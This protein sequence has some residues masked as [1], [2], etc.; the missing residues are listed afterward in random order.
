MALDNVLEAIDRDLEKSLE[1]LYA[2][3]R[4]PSVST[5]PAYRGDCR[6]AAD[7]L[8]QEL[9]ALH[10]KAD[11]RETKGLPMVVGHS[12]QGRQSKKPHILFYGHYDVQPPDPLDQW[13][14]PPFEPWMASTNGAKRIVARGSA[15]DKGQLMTFL[16]ACR[17][18]IAVEGD[19]PLLVTVLFEGEEETG[20]P[21]LKPFLDANKKELSADLA[22]VCDTDMWD[23]RTPA[24]TTMLRGLVME[25]LTIIGSNRDLHSGLFG[26]AAIN[27]IR[28]LAHIL[29][30]LHDD[31]GRITIPGF[32]DGAEDLPA[33]VRAQWKNL[34]F[35]EQKFLGEFGLKRPAGEEGRSVLEQI[36]ARP[37]CDVNGI[38]SGYTGVGAKTVIPSK[39]SAKVSFRIVGEQDPLKVQGAFRDFVKKR[40]PSDCTAEFQSHGASPALQLP[41]SSPYLTKA[42][43]ALEEEWGT[44]AVLKGCGASIPIVGSFKRDLNMDSLLIGYGL[45]DDRVHSPNEKYN[46]SS[47]HK[48]TR[49][50]A[51]ILAGLAA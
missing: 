7:W 2:L 48:G 46:L 30:D 36:W 17:A 23:V 40:L 49:S 20:S 13:E 28:V 4:I 18:I 3:L 35:D 27:P 6:K 10:F 15:D 31:K 25:E 38:L 50:W 47:F 16:E 29:A 12:R 44:P 34:G 14:T 43:T 39:A 45:D 9:T 8:A 26:G 5:D 19:L 33:A 42:L 51:R 22:F 11:V 41:L 21:S 37:T 1:R 24:V 32:Y